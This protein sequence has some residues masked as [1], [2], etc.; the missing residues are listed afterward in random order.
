MPEWFG[1]ALYFCLRRSTCRD[2]LLVRAQSFERNSKKVT[3]SV[4]NA[5]QFIERVLG[6]TCA[7]EV[8]L[9]FVDATL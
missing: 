2:S 9:V 3:E 5:L 6:S 1:F 4:N 7:A 8:S